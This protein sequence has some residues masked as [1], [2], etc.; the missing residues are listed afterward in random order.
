MYIKAFSHQGV[1]NLAPGK[2]FLS[3]GLNIFYGDNGAGK[4]SILEAISFLTTGRSF[5][6]S[7]LEHIITERGEELVVFGLSA[8]EK[9]IGVAF[10]KMNKTRM[11]K[12]NGK[13]LNRLS[14]LTCLYPTQILSPESY[15]LIDSGP[16][17]RRKYLDWCLFHVKHSYHSAW[18]NYTNILKQR[19]ALLRQG[20]RLSV[21]EQLN[22][23]DKQLC[24]AALIVNT[25]RKSIL[26]KLEESLKIT[27]SD[28]AVNFCDTLSLSYYPGFTD[29]L[30]DKLRMS[31]KS[32]FESGNTK[33]GPHKAD[34]RIKVDGYLAKDYLSRG[35]K[36]I[37]IN[38]LFLSQTLLLKQITHKESL[39]LIDD[40]TSEL[41]ISNQKALLD[42]LLAQ[43]NVQIVLSCL[44]QDSLKWFNKGY[45]SAHMFHVEHGTITSITDTETHRTN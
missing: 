38:A 28:L 15:H 5:R 25:E 11:I 3:K 43:E 14:D 42:M 6:T 24:D 4:S 19:N 7:K 32:D 40:F 39:F 2:L 31:L 12:I 27:M 16:S 45:N 35:Q 17:E 8:D 44:Q 20:D 41:D 21:N 34:L 37:L 36:K 30:E 26:V 18:K 9:R 10:Q 23:W 1:R 13:K 33:F 29:N 22:I